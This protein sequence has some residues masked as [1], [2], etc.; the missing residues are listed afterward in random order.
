MMAVE[1]E[2]ATTPL[3]NS[4]GHAKPAV[5]IQTLQLIRIVPFVERAIQVSFFFGRW[6]PFCSTPTKYRRQS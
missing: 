2:E 5:A 3:S 4:A 1:E 6:I